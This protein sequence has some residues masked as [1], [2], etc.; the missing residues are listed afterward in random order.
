[1]TGSTSAAAVDGEGSNINFA[2]DLFGQI[3]FHLAK[4]VELFQ[5][6]PTS[7]DRLKRIAESGIGGQNFENDESLSGIVMMEANSILQMQSGL[8]QIQ[9]SFAMLK[10]IQ[11]NRCK[12]Y[13]E[14]AQRLMVE[15]QNK[16]SVAV[17]KQDVE[18][19]SF[20]CCCFHLL[21][22]LY[23]QFLNG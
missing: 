14:A 17:A 12:P 5:H 3:E 18:N 10:T 16:D 7:S 22:E 9:S 4:S 8:A 2:S 11:D 21:A 6:I 19:V 15:M 20:S 23:F 1:M 13:E